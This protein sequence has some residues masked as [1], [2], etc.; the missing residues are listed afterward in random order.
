[1]RLAT[2]WRRRTVI[3]RGTHQ[4]MSKL[5]AQPIVMDQIGNL[6]GIKRRKPRSKARVGSAYFVDR[7]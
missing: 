6:G 7:P 5:D 1:M 3:G 2:L 4:R